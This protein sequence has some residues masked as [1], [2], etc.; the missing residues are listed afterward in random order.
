MYTITI[1]DQE[2]NVDV[3]SKIT[4]NDPYRKYGNIIKF[5]TPDFDVEA[6]KTFRT[7]DSTEF[8]VV[9][10]IERKEPVIV[11]DKPLNKMLKP[12]LIEYANMNGIE[13]DPKAT[14]G[15]ILEAIENRYK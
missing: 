11:S 14:K 15:K 12:E 1:E 7:G 2:L 10:I 8:K 4:L 6:K 13:I 3:G 9:S 5:C